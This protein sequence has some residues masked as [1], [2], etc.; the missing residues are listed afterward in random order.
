MWLEDHDTFDLEADELQEGM[1]K[2]KRKKLSK[3]H[4]Q[5]SRAKPATSSRF[6]A[7]R[8]FNV[9]G[10]ED[11]II[12]A[13]SYNVKASKPWPARI[14]HAKEAK[15]LGSSSRRSSG[16]RRRCSLR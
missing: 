10:I 13:T 3:E 6:E 5:A 16:S 7:N 14:M 11:G 15:A 4:R 2:W 12:L 8:N 1:N 9:D